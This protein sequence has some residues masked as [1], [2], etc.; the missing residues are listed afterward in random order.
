MLLFFNWIHVDD[1]RTKPRPRDG[2]LHEPNEYKCLLRATLGNKKISTVV[3]SKTVCNCYDIHQMIS[4]CIFIISPSINNTSSGD[5]SAASGSFST[6]CVLTYPPVLTHSCRGQHMMA[7]TLIQWH[8][9]TVLMFPSL[10]PLYSQ[11]NRRTLWCSKQDVH[12]QVLFTY[13]WTMAFLLCSINSLML[14]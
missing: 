12:I 6:L 9:T 3:C 2:G 14:S 4:K 8:S 11:K 5:E 1:G 7:I 10:V 13:K